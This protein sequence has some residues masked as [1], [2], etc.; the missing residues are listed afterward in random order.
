MSNFVDLT[1]LR[2]GRL[3]VEKRS[4]KKSN[5]GVLW[6][7]KCDC[8]GFSESNSLKLRKGHTSSCGCLKKESKPTLT[9]GMANKTRTYRTW[10]EMRQRCLNKNSDKWQWYGGR[11][12]L[13]CAEWNSFERFLS[14]MGDRPEGKTIDRIDNDG[15]YCKDNCRWADQKEQTRKQS[16]CVVTV[17]MAKSIK[18]DY[19]NSEKYRGLQSYISK[20][21]KVSR[22]VI[23]SILK[24]RSWS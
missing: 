1:G 4:D 22:T 10:K 19:A 3:V 24:G 2:F 14:D 23:N 18:D 11:G 6:I 8:G 9:H 5:A 20:K 16:H 21:Y 13:I 12:I 7:C 15:N 17:D